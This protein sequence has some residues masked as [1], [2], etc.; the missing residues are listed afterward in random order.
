[1]RTQLLFSV[2]VCIAVSGCG[3]GNSE[4][5][6]VPQNTA[7]TESP[8]EFISEDVPYYLIETMDDGSQLIQYAVEIML[9]QTHLITDSNGRE[10]VRS[11]MVPIVEERR[12]T[13][14]PGEDISEFLRVNSGDRIID[15]EP[16]VRLDEYVDPAPAPPES[17]D[18]VIPQ[19]LQ[20]L[21]SIAVRQ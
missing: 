10:E 20:V 2:L 11:V 18:A 1:M 3:C 6:C 9:P 7:N 13:V 21:T 4:H 8:D 5:S 19:Q 17:S 14:P 12:A 16:D 15:H